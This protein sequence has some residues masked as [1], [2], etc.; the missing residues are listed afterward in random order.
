MDPT[1]VGPSGSPDYDELRAH[2]DRVTMDGMSILIASLD[3]LEAMKRAA[4]RPKDRPDR[5]GRRL[6][7]GPPPM[8]ATP[9]PRPR[10]EPE[11]QP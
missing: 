9:P 10:P 7:P 11:Q 3:D 2:A 5:L 1:E 6:P 4:N 8:S